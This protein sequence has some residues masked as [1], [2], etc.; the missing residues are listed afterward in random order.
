MTPLGQNLCATTEATP[1]VASRGA[2]DFNAA[3]AP[4]FSSGFFPEFFLERRERDDLLRERDREDDELDENDR[5]RPRE[6][7]RWLERRPRGDGE[8]EKDNALG[9]LRERS[10][11]EEI[12]LDRSYLPLLCEDS[13]LGGI[14]LLRLSRPAAT[15]AANRGAMPWQSSLNG[16]VSRC[17]LYFA[18]VRD[19][20]VMIRAIRSMMASCNEGSE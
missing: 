8:R 6:R 14:G 11:A 16:L 2:A 13:M 3:I 9:L 17:G 4:P 5:E 18:V 10:R 19:E 1:I 7:V 12:D 20:I 15:R